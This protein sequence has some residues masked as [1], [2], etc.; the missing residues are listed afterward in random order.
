MANKEHILGIDEGTTTVR[1]A[2]IDGHGEIVGQAREPISPRF[3]SAGWVETDAEDLW[4]RT[5]KVIRSALTHAGLEMA[6][7]EA[8]GITNQRSSAALFDKRGSPLG[9]LIGWQDQR[10]AMR[11]QQ[12]LEQGILIVSNMAASKYEWLL[13]TH[14]DNQRD[15]LRLGTV[16]TYLA[17]RMTEGEVHASDHSNFSLTGLYDLFSGSVNE[18]TAEKL[19]IDPRMLPTLVGT[20]ERVGETS[21]KIMGASVPIAS[22]S[23]DQHAAMYAQGCHDSGDLEL[24]LGTSGML[25]RN[26]GDSL[27]EVPQGSYPLVLWA[28]DGKRTFCSESPVFTAG[29]AMEWLCQGIGIASDLESLEPLARSVDSSDGVFAVP[30]FSGL[31]G[32]HFD[33]S[34]RALIGG[35]SRGS[36]RAHVARAV[37]E[38]VAWRCAEAFSVLSA[39]ETK[40]ALRVAGGAAAN[41]LLLELLADATGIVV[42]R[43]RVLER[44]VLGAAALAGRASG[45][46]SDADTRARWG[47]G[48]RFEPRMGDDE[49][50]AG[51]ERWAARIA[52]ARQAGS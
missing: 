24:E 23:G 13:Q 19:A 41:D 2:V 3:P 20:S 51:R 7:L 6:D 33:L 34:A 8:V 10:T 35:L 44:A 49:R 1:A 31:G 43:P 50:A 22:L 4:Q 48:A 14:G 9:P 15:S 5:Q 30:A 12:L 40:S 17:A 36:T 25:K 38:G 28:L 32:P 42:E 47:I 11:C 27:T 18:S 29:A 45:L 52:L 21:Q 16:D 26:E 39:G 37:F 46:I